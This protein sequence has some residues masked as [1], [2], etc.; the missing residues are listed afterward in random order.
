MILGPGRISKSIRTSF[1]FERLSQTSNRYFH[2]FESYSPHPRFPKVDASEHGSSGPVT[3]GYNAHVWK[4]SDMFIQ[5]CINA[6]I[7]F[8][9][10]FNT[11]RGTLGVN[12]VRITFLHARTGLTR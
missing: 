5:A 1:D 12:K 7:P 11:S 6:G 10:D 9:P 4:G 3:I 8:N 2:K